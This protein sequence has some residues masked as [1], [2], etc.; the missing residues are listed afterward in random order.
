MVRGWMV[1]GL[2]AVPR[3]KNGV[4]RERERERMCARERDTRAQTYLFFFMLTNVNCS[5]MKETRSGTV[6]RQTRM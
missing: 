6:V 2:H 4:E 5:V 1:C 3:N